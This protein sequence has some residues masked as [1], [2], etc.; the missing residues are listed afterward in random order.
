MRSSFI[1]ILG[2][3]LIGIAMFACKKSFLER[4]PEA[5]FNEAALANAFGVQSTL[6]AAYAALDGWTDQGWNNAAGNPW[7]T[8]GSNWVW[9]SVSTDDAYP[10]SQPNDQLQVELINKYEWQPDMAYLRAKF[11]TIYWGIGTTNI[12]LRLL[13][14]AADMSQ[15]A[16]D[17][18]I[19][20]S[21]FLR[22]HYH[23]EG[24]KMWKNIPYIDETV[25]AEY[26]LKNDVDIFPKIVADFQEAIAKLPEKANNASGR[27]TKSA[28]QA[29]LARAYM[30]NGRYSDA[31]PLLNAVISGNR[32][33]LGDNF[34]D[35]FD[36][37]KQNN[38]EFLF[39]FKASV[40]DGSAES[41]N[42]N[43]GDRLNFPHGS[44][45][46][47]C[48]GFHQPS[49]NLLNAYKTDAT[50][51][52]PMAN[53]NTANFSQAT[54]FLDPRADWTIGRTGMPFLDWGTHQ[55]SWVRD[56]GYCGFLSPKKNQFHRAQVNNL[57]TASGW[58]NAPNAIDIPFIRYSDVLLMAAECEIETNGNLSRARDLINIVRARAG[59]TAQGAGTSEA[60]IIQAL[61]AAVGGI[62]TGTVNGTQYKI[63]EYPSAGWTQ[64]VARD[65][66]RWERR[67]ELAMEG[68]RLFD[69]RRWGVDA[70]VLNAFV[71]AEQPRRSQLFAGV[72]TVSAK[73]RLYPIPSQEIELSRINGEAQLKQNP[74]Y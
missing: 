70:A 30:Y 20:E 47:S 52:L 18:V 27:A 50:T 64:A 55:D 61:P 2:A 62:V 3:F 24:Y 73:H 46:T 53:F 67:L 34:H 41:M 6:I 38:N 63:G 57:S 72:Q 43:W 26:R 66:V 7:P 48:C 10:G 51:G 69:L 35:N 12:T 1:K 13:P 32:Y 21:K 14:K 56:G 68:Y 31:L 28:A 8:A 33:S 59:K 40:N 74:G 9:G 17:Q 36:A 5:A 45:V 54:N 16:K 49:Q 4:V 60:T 23:F 37:A 29:Y 11:Q 22:G 19:G 58:S 42:G 71:A 25:V 15:A 44:T 39:V 65:A